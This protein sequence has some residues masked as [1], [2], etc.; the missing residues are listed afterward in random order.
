MYLAHRIL[1]PHNLGLH[2]LQF[3]TLK[4]DLG[5]SVVLVYLL[6]VVDLYLLS[7]MNAETFEISYTHVDTLCNMD[8]LLFWQW[9]LLVRGPCNVFLL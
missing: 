2:R 8:H 7:V 9:R 1:Y 6:R 5:I 3:C 4:S